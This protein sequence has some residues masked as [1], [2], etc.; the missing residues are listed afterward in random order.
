MKF[1]D[2]GVVLKLVSGETVI[3]QVVSDTDKNLLIRDPYII[4]VITEKKDDGIKAS[5][6]YSDWFLGSATRVH[7]IRKDHIISA[8]LPDD[9]LKAHYGELVE[10]RDFKEGGTT[11]SAKKKTPEPQSFWDSLNFGLDGQDYRNN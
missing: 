2:M 7:M 8:A 3:C 9:N 5:T 1:D 11:A 6:F 10:I 4:N